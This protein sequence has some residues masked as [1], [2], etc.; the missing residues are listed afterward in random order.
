LNK[1]TAVILLLILLVLGAG[2]YWY[3]FMRGNGGGDGGG[4]GGGSQGFIGSL[5]DA[6]KLGKAM[7]CTVDT[8]YTKGTYYV[9]SGML[10]GTATSSGQTMSFLVRDNCM[11]YWQ[12]DQSQGFKMCW[13]PGSEQADDWEENLAQAS[14][15]YNCQPA[16]VS[17]S[18]FNLP[19]GVDFVDYGSF[20]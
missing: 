20:Q 15:Q 1:K 19:S 8:E 7:K 9:K 17:N 6:L 18:I 14:E 11:Y 5:A 13:E 12:E 3:F 2:G 10:A 4:T 16:S